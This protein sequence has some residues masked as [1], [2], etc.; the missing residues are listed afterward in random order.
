[1]KRLFLGLT[2]VL[3][4][5]TSSCATIKPVDRMELL[6]MELSRWQ[7]F[8]ADGVVNVNYTGLTMRKMFVL[9]K[10]R[11]E[12]RLDILDGGAFGIS[13]SPLISIYLADYLAV[14]SPLVPQLQ[15]LAQIGFGSGGGYLSVLNDVD[16]LVEKYG[17]LIL[18][19]N[20]LD[21]SGTSLLF[22]PAMKLLKIMNPDSGVS[23][24]FNYTSKGDPDKV[25]LSLGKSGS[26][27]LLVDSIKY[28]GTEVTP[29]PRPQE[30]SGGFEIPGFL[31]DLL[32]KP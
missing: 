28:G 29:L 17:S 11:D 24:D 15:A 23:V 18:E 12:A 26:M 13:P 9:N 16:D 4:I 2:L 27:E 19:D 32:K 3:A 7:D 14:D 22:S 25:V 30:N 8:R 10:T 20:T 31:K 5:L 21:L 6:R 1:M